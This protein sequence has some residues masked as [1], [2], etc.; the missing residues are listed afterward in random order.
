VANI[1]PGGPFF[2]IVNMICFINQLLAQAAT[3][4]STPP[5]LQNSRLGFLIVGI[6]ATLIGITSYLLGKRAKARAA[7]R[8]PNCKAVTTGG[9]CPKCGTQIPSSA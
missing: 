3:S 6:I 4:P 7:G 5:P 8:C 1:L 9:F 2:A